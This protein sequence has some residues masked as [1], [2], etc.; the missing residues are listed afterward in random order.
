MTRPRATVGV[1]DHAGWAALMTVGADGSVLD[2]RR[3]ELVD[4]AD[5]TTEG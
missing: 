3:V 1:S 2:R 5:D 4:P